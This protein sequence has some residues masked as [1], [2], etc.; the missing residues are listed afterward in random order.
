MVNI[1]RQDQRVRG[2]TD[3]P[4]DETDDVCR[5]ANDL[6]QL[7]RETM[8]TKQ[9]NIRS[10]TYVAPTRPTQSCS[11]N[12]DRHQ[13][14][15]KRLV[16]PYSS[17]SWQGHASSRR[18]YRARPTKDQQMIIG[19]YL[20]DR[21]LDILGGT[22]SVSP[23]AIR[24]EVLVDVQ[25]ELFSSTSRVADL[26]DGIVGPIDPSRSVGPFLA[27]E[28]GRVE[29]VVSLKFVFWGTKRTHPGNKMYWDEAPACLIAFTEACNVLANVPMLGIS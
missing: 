10:T 7:S 5:L 23:T 13:S 24:V 18:C 14:R 17:S 4:D 6:F 25:Q 12:R 29:R 22:I 26:D 2:G 27:A 21:R 15:S 16:D 20:Q 11:W 1:E 3:T 28:E 8:K 9:V 19:V